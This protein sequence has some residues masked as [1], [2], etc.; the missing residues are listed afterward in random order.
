LTTTNEPWLMLHTDSREFHLLPDMVRR[1]GEAGI[2]IEFVPGHDAQEIAAF[3][4]R[5]NGLML[6][7]GR[8]DGALLDAL[9]N[10]RHLARVGTGYELI[11]VEAARRRGIIVTNVPDFCTEELSDH[12]M[13]CILGFARR[14]PY[15][16]FQAREHRWQAAHE[17]PPMHRVRGRTL[18]ILGFGRS[19]L[20]TAEKAR[21]FGM[22]VL[23]WSRTPRP[24]ALAKV[25]ARAATFE[26]VLG[27]AY[28]SLHLPLTDATRGL[29][30]AKEFQRMTPETVLIN[31][32]RGSIV[33]TDA[34]VDALASGRL[35]GAALDVVHPSPLPPEH[36]L[37]AMPNVWITSHSAAF[38]LEARDDAQTTVLE[39]MILVRSGK[40]PRN[41][42]PEPRGAV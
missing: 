6:Y 41:P 24:D 12:V 19:G 38:S 9:P 22:E 13:A 5:C 33:D 26:E 36:P 39:D 16:L 27:C 37:W 21:A 18:G 11:D 20:R 4:E 8:V 40:P 28:V 29:I 23:T 35:A 14:F 2:T 31:I 10:C 3:G 15:L 42:V 30:G 32:A 34:M 25:G 1:A 7:R 17:V